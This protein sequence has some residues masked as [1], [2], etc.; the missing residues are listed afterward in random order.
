MK[1]NRH[2]IVTSQYQN[3]ITINANNNNKDNLKLTE[4]NS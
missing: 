3:N 4:P 1:N 2:V